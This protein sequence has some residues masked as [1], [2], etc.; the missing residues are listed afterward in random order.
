MA[1]LTP[2]QAAKLIDHTNLRADAKAEDIRR[3]CDE[4]VEYG[5][6]AV[7]VNSFQVR[8]AAQLLQGTGVGV[9]ATVAF[10]LGQTSTSM[11]VAEALDAIGNGATE[12]DYVTN[13]SLA[14]DGRFDLVEDE[15]ESI[16]AACHEEGALVK[17]IFENCY[18]DE[19]QK[20][21]MCIVASSVRPD[22]VKTSTGFGSGGATLEDVRYMRAHVPAEVQVKAAGGIRTVEDF[23]AYVDAGATRIGCSAGIPIVEALRERQ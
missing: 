12:I 8:R 14:R 21:S 20:M 2:E 22:F 16:V 1:L 7:C 18:L 4:A 11:K 10:P 9:S 15:M 19:I 13:V 5:F 23:L 17:V 6:G 3:L